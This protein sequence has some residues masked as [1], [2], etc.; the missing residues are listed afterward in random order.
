MA[1]IFC[2]IAAGERRAHIVYEDDRAIA[3]RDIHPQAPTHILI[4]PRDHIDGPAE[5]V[6]FPDGL[7]T[8]LAAVSVIGALA[9]AAGWFRSLHL[10]E[11]RSGVFMGAG[12]MAVALLVTA[13]INPSTGGGHSHAEGG[14]GHDANQQVDA[15]LRWH[16]HPPQPRVPQVDRRRHEQGVDP[17]PGDEPHRAEQP[18]RPEGDAHDG[19]RLPADG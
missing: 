9:L 4:I 3:F 7:S 17:A 12:A 5:A 15:P 11:A 14:H 8:F 6:A 16:R 13:S 19:Q 18:D 10:G 1:C 2:Q